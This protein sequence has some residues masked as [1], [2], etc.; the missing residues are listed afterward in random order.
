MYVECSGLETKRPF[1]HDLQ[2]WEEVSLSNQLLHM[3]LPSLWEKGNYRIQTYLSSDP[4]KCRQF[5]SN[6]L[7]YSNSGSLKLIPMSIQPKKSNLRA[8]Y[9]IRAY[10]LDG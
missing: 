1:P 2:G 5:I 9:Y 6:G 8:A 3:Y 7:Q 10:M 4:Y